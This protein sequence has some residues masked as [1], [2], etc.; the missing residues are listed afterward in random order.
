MCVCVCVCEC[1]CESVVAVET[2]P[3]NFETKNRFFFHC[4]FFVVVDKKTCWCGH[5]WVWVAKRCI[6]KDLGGTSGRRMHTMF[7]Y[8]ARGTLR[9]A[10]EHE[11]CAG[12]LTWWQRMRV[13][14]YLVLVNVQLWMVRRVPYASYWLVRQANTLTQS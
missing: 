1:V 2:I 11:Q 6:N 9:A 5:V 14:V 7:E 4:C 12:R 13:W 10:S 3:N 8:A